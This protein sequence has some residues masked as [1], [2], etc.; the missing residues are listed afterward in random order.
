MWQNKKVTPP[1]TNNA[2]IVPGL[3]PGP[4][5]CHLIEIGDKGGCTR[6]LCAHVFM[7]K[8]A[9]KCMRAFVCLQA[10]NNHSRELKSVQPVK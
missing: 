1:G 6:V 9:Y 7:C 4:Y 3:D 5:Y 10:T 2:E 8:C